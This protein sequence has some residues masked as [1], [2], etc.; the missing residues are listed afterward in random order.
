[1]NWAN[2]DLSSLEHMREAKPC[3]TCILRGEIQNK[4]MA[5]L[6]ESLESERNKVRTLQEQLH[7]LQQ[8]I[9]KFPPA[10]DTEQSVQAQF[11]KVDASAWTFEGYVHNEYLERTVVQQ[12]QLL[13]DL[14]QEVEH[15][16]MEQKLRQHEMTREALTSQR[17]FLENH[18]RFIQEESKMQQ[19]AQALRNSL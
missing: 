4:E 10:S 5:S 11:T 3:M 14:Q 15:L 1:M 6:R 12:A 9:E 19:A 16:R 17:E 13:R 7:T 18:Q 8:R 2:R